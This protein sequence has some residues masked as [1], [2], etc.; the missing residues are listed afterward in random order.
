MRSLPESAGSRA[1]DIERLAASTLRTKRRALE[2]DLDAILGA[3]TTCP[4]TSDLLA[5]VARARQQ[6]LT[7]CDFPGKVDPT[8][9]VSERKL[10]PCVIQ[11]KVTNGYRAKW[12]ADFEASVRTA[13]DT[14]RLAGAGPFLTLLQI[15]VP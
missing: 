4:L 10:R 2:R 1:H 14:A 7:F 5:K 8:N 9:N 3:P 11:R 13:L 15:V 12:A 6:L